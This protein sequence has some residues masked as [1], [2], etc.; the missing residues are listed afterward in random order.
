MMKSVLKLT[1][2]FENK[3]DIILRDYLA[4]ERTRLANET[5]LLSYI[6]AALYLLLSGLAVVKVDT[7]DNIKWLGTLALI[8]SALFAFFGLVRFF[9]L[10]KRLRK[11]Y[12]FSNENLEKEVSK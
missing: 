11:Y 4:L 10:R 7:F 2:E 12:Q 9:S 6:K 8:L 1:P 5:T 3:A